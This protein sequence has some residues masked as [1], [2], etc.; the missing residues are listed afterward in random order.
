VL[1][2]RTVNYRG[3]GFCLD[4]VKGLHEP[5]QVRGTDFVAPGR[6]GQYAGNRVHH[7][8]EILIEGYIQG[9]GVSKAAAQEDFH[10]KTAAIMAT[11]DRDLAAGALVVDGGDYG[12]PDSATW[13]I[14]ARCADAIGGPMLNGWTVQEWSIKLISLDPEWVVT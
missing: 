2:F 13:T 5:S 9:M 11:L 12:L 1:K 14:Q 8:R 10:T 6:E 4:I 7:A 3:T